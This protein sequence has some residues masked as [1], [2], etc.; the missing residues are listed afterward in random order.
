MLYYVT[1]GDRT[2]KVEL[3]PEG[4]RIDGRRV[5]AELRRVEGTRV[6]S[7]LADGASHRVLAR[8]DGG[9]VWDL[10]LRGRRVSATVVDERTRTILEMTGAGARELGP[11]PLRAPMP[12]L[13]VKVEVV[14]GDVVETG[15]GIVIVEAMKMENE[16]VAERP[17]RVAAVR[18]E[19][20]EA[21]EKNQ[22]LVEFDEPGEVDEEE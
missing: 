3:G 8:R 2:L 18:V 14:E 11:G 5:D 10:H 12:G 21:V 16:L 19:P 4:A 6:H 17:G 9:G 1:V 7:L 13:V 20:G 15:Q 22:V